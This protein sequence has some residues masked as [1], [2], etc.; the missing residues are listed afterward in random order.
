M[1]GAL[2]YYADDQL[3]VLREERLTS[4]HD[5]RHRQ[6]RPSGDR[7]RLAQDL[8]GEIHLIDFELSFRKTLSKAQN[9]RGRA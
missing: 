3:A 4:L 8:Q 2:S 7:R 6:G 9:L 1:S 5:L